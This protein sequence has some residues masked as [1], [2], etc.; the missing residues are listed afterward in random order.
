[1]HNVH[2]D[3]QPGREQLGVAKTSEG[4]GCDTLDA[5]HC[6]PARLARPRYHWQCVPCTRQPTAHWPIDT[7]S[8]GLGHQPI[9]TRHHLPSWPSHTTTTPHTLL[10][11][12]HL[13]HIMNYIHT[14]L[15]IYLL[16]L[17]SIFYFYLY[18]IFLYCIFVLS[19]YSSP[20]H[21]CL[22]IYINIR[23]RIISVVFLLY[24][25]YSIIYIFYQI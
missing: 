8:Q 11:H 6:E 14:L 15:Y 5:G 12:P 3:S 16:S 19:S 17:Y 9:C 4:T 25:I 1:M 10:T 7:V 2:V 13:Q 18:I 23:N 22:S 20:R 24:I 21:I